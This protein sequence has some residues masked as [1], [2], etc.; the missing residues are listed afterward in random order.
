MADVTIRR[1]DYQ[2]GREIKA[3]AHYQYIVNGI[4]LDGSKFA[5]EELVQEGTCLIKDDVTGLY[6][7]YADGDNAGT[8]IF[9]AGKSDPVIIDESIK[10]KVKDDGT[11]PDVTAGQVIVHGSVYEGMLIGVTAIF[12]DALKGAIRFV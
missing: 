11:N 4:T 7:K 1:K 2:A 3:S 6:E 9:P 8:P 12:K 10:F 5:V